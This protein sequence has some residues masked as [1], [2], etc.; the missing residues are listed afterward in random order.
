MRRLKPPDLCVHTDSDSLQVMVENQPSLIHKLFLLTT[1]TM[2]RHQMM[3]RVLSTEVQ[4]SP[5]QRRP[6]TNPL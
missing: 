1:Q 2:E 3:V 4:S 5:G 6:A